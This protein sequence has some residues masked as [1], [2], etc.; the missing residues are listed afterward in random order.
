M[1][2]RQIKF[3]LADVATLAGNLG[4]VTAA[5]LALFGPF[6]PVFGTSDRWGSITWP[7]FWWTVAGAVALSVTGWLAGR[8]E[9]YDEDS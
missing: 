1:S 5:G 8:T 3:K 7:P 4:A 2:T 9:T 6:G